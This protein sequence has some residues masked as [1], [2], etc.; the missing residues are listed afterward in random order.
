ML[1]DLMDAVHELPHLVTRWEQ[2][3]E[4]LL[5]QILSDFDGKWPNENIGLL[6]TYERAIGSE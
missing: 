5:R 3:D 6:A 1:A 4:V 2:C